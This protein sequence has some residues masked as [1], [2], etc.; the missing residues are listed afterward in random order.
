MLYN[1][2]SSIWS[3][4]PLKPTIFLLMV[5]QDTLSITES[6]VLKSPT[7]IVLLAISLFR[8]VN[9]SFIHLG[10]VMLRAYLII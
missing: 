8:F 6:G 9:V 3:V 5:Y 10:A 7:I 1:S 2:V 4:V